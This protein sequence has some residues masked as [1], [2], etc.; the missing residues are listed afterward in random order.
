MADKED[1]MP[2]DLVSLPMSTDRAASQS[3]L[4]LANR[5]YLGWVGDPI[6]TPTTA[7]ESDERFALG[8]PSVFAFTVAYNLQAGM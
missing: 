3:A 1:S 4:D 2:L 6:A 5:E 7:A 8:V